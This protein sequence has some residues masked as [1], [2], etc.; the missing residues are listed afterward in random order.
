MELSLRRFINCLFYSFVFATLCAC[1]G[2]GDASS[3]AGDG[4]QGGGNIAPV[5]QQN[6]IFSG[7]QLPEICEFDDGRLRNFAQCD[8]TFEIQLAQGNKSDAS[9]AGQISTDGGDTWQNL[10]T[11]TDLTF[12]LPV[13]QY[14][15]QVQIRATMSYQ[16]VSSQTQALNFTLLANSINM[17]DAGDFAL[18]KAIYLDPLD[19]DATHFNLTLPNCVNE[20]QD[21]SKV[22]L[23]RN[24]IYFVE[25]KSAAQIKLP[26]SRL[27][28]NDTL[29]AVCIDDAN[30][31]VQAPGQIQIRLQADPSINHPP[32]VS[33]SALPQNVQKYQGLIRDAQSFEV[34]IQASDED[35]D[36]LA[37]S[38]QVQTR[39]QSLALTL[40]DEYCATLDTETFAGENVS[41]LATAN[42]GTDTAQTTYE[43]G[44]IYPDTLPV[45]SAN[46]SSCQLEQS[47]Q[48]VNL[49]LPRDTEFDEYQVQVVNINN[50]QVLR[51][52]GQV[53]SG[54]ASTAQLSFSCD[55]LGEIQYQ[56]VTLSRGKQVSS[57]T[58][59]HSVT[60]QV[61]QLPELKFEINA[62]VLVP[63]EQVIQYRDNQLI[64]ICVIADDADN[65]VLTYS[66]NYQWAQMDEMPLLL[67]NDCG[68]IDTQGRGGQRLKLIG[69]VDDGSAEIQK[70]N[71]LGE[72]HADTIQFASTQS[73]ACTLGNQMVSYSVNIEPDSEGDDHHLQIIN[74][75]TQAVIKNLGSVTSGQFDL[76]CDQIGSTV[77]QLKNQSRELTAI[78]NNYSH[79]VTAS[80]NQKPTLKYQISGPKFNEQFRDNST[81]EVCIESSD[82]EG[83]PVELSGEIIFKHPSNSNLDV[84]QELALDSQNCMPVSTFNKGGYELIVDLLASD[85]VIE[86][87]IN[88]SQGFIHQDQINIAKSDNGECTEGSGFIEYI[89]N[90]DPDIEGDSHQLTVIDIADN[91]VIASSPV[92]NTQ[93]SFSL[94][95]QNISN[96]KNFYIRNDSRGLSTYSLVYRHQVN[97]KEN[98]EPE[99]K[100]NLNQP[101][102]FDGN[103][104]DNQSFDVCLEA[105]DADGDNL[106]YSLKYQIDEQESAVT[107]NN[108]CGRVSTFGAGGKTLTITA[109]ANDGRAT[110]TVTEP[111]PEKPAYQI[112]AD[113]VQFAFTSNQSCAIGDSARVYQINLADDLEGD[114]QNVTVYRADNSVLRNLGQSR[115]FSLSC[116]AAAVTEF[117]LVNESRGLSTRSVTYQHTVGNQINT[118]P[119][120]NLSV[121]PAPGSAVVDRFS[122]QIRDQQSLQICADVNDTETP[123]DQLNVQVFYRFDNQ[124]QQILSLNQQ[125]GLIDLS[126]R[127]GQNLVIQGFAGDGTETGNQDLNLGTIHKDTI[128]AA[129]SNS[130]TCRVGDEKNDFIV[131]VSPDLEGDE[132]NLD[133]IDLQTGG[134]LVELDQ[135]TAGNFS[136]PCNELGAT[137]FVIRTTSRGLTQNSIVYSHVVDDTLNSNPQLSFNL[138]GSETFN[139]IVRDAQSLQVCLTATDSDNDPIS[140][141]AMYQFNGEP[142][143]NLKLNEQQCGFIDLIGRGGDGLT[144][145]GFADDG[146]AESTQLFEIDQIHQDTLETPQTV[147]SSCSIGESSL[148]YSIDLADDAENDLRQILVK[149]QPSG[150]L[151]AQFDE[152]DDLNQFDFSL[153]CEAVGE[154]L[155]TLIA[156]SRDL[157]VESDIYTHTVNPSLT[158]VVQAWMTTADQ[159]KLLAPQADLT[160]RA[161]MGTATNQIDV[162]DSMSYQNIEGFGA[163]LTD[164]AASLIFESTDSQAIVSRLFEPEQGAGLNRVRISLSGLGEY[165]ARAAQSY[166]DMPSGLTDPDL[167]FF[168]TEADN[169]YFLPVLNSILQQNDAI[170][171][172]AAS[173]SAPA[174]MKDTDS[175]NGGSLRLEFYDEYAKYLSKSLQSYQTKGIEIASFSL[176]NQPHLETNYPS[177]LWD[178]TDY[179][180]FFEDFL[181]PQFQAD[182]I[183]SEL[184]VWDGNWTDYDSQQESDIALF[185]TDALNNDFIYGRAFGVALQ[186]YQANNGS[187]D[188]AKAITQITSLT[189]ARP[190]YLTSCRNQ[191]NGRTF[192][193]YLT[194]T[195][196]DMIMPFFEA[197]ASGIMLD[198]LI[199]DS[200]FGPYQNA[201]TN[202]RA[203]LTK[204]SDGEITENAEFYAFAHFSRFIQTGAKRIES[205]QINGVIR[206]QAFK[207][208][209]NSIVLVLVNQANS[210]QPIDINWQGQSTLLQ[211]PALSVATLI[212]NADNSGVADLQKIQQASQL[213]QDSLSLVNAMRASSGLY[214]DH[215]NFDLGN[216]TAGAISPAATGLGLVALSIEHQMQW[217][218]NATN[219][220]LATLDTL[221]AENDAVTPARDDFGVFAKRLAADGSEVGDNYSVLE[222]AYLLAGAKFAQNVFNNSQI[223]EKVDLLFESVD[224]QGV[225]ENTEQGIVIVERDFAQQTLETQGVY[226]QQMLVVWLA[227]QAGELSAKTVWDNYYANGELANRIFFDDLAVPANAEGESISAS[228]HQLNY[229]LINPVLASANYRQLFASHAQAEQN[230]WLTEHNQASYVWGFG[231]GTDNTQAQPQFNSLTLHNTETAHAPTIAG[232]IPANNDYLD[233]ILAWQTNDI[234]ILSTQI[235][236]LEIPWR[237]QI[238]DINWQAQRLDMLSIAPLFMGITAHPGL[239]DIQFY[240]LNNQVDLN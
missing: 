120:I 139:E 218:T 49:D 208:P 146:I 119:T 240:R 150:N 184:W 2:S 97:P 159:S 96:S 32:I 121:L 143:R 133:V 151:I 140:Y 41:L 111:E 214:F 220:V 98:A 191:N 169:E 73:Q 36:E 137:N 145:Q 222:T 187:A 102:R 124:A 126:N 229:Y 217:N 70:V 84:S 71:N 226:D 238:E 95:C 107:L 13:A 156:I 183:N 109:T 50:A 116:N 100:L 62:D 108:G 182:A 12:S 54:Q 130:G 61:N 164:S 203:L 127:G 194:D 104:R 180:I 201:C 1:G 118:R 142:Q 81:L 66:L 86:E 45:I 177:M 210:E 15:G 233:D 33:F 26:R 204:Q 196:A 11:S 221:L 10:S 34:C 39:S 57:Q 215:L 235:G 197:G 165:V 128:Q 63:N 232:F 83:M 52:L 78:S 211:L 87:G 149:Q 216:I 114:E 206:T 236:N 38:L 224:W 92:T 123:D 231:Y 166:D 16:Q 223:N 60:A 141:R 199:L 14:N 200:D 157:E 23:N 167:A 4:D 55:Q 90:I 135:I 30:A 178:N 190:V 237:Y 59:S 228:I 29:T 174:W 106:T 202:C 162:S 186:C 147:S 161:G 171:V 51:D 213:A 24:N 88:E 21:L 219:L 189:R 172:D 94:S 9:F 239:L 175:L 179:Q 40:N 46:N 153:P 82:P 160:L 99:L 3:E 198:N 122:G 170:K 93:A 89:I 68:Q 67:N 110:V 125:C 56:I 113:S 115:S 227:K 168:S 6:L 5:L 91:S 80:P 181:F 112:H 79:T 19:F 20:Q 117:Y 188:V 193:Q 209:D 22:V 17:L 74:A 136:L 212:W 144:I 77:F 173:W 129:I 225:I 176:Q 7:N 58:Y 25:Q 230:Y 65:D 154:T 158:N 134:V 163:G 72:I 234:G 35:N 192:A 42:D 43:L 64:E 105:T 44:P 28:D 155:F 205:S 185:A 8:L 69:K 131:R 101:E 47:E 103:I 207:N 195:S 148:I 76:A 18:D 48:K 27:A 75:D 53:N 132:Y 31:A 152:G 37:I 85:G 138:I